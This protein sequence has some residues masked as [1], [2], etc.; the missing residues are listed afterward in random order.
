MKS[1]E[2]DAMVFSSSYVIISYNTVYD[3]KSIAGAFEVNDGTEIFM[4]STTLSFVGS[5]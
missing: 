4:P 5:M 3:Y 2:T 1:R